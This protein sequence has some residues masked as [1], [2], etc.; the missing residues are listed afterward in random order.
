MLPRSSALSD[1]GRRGLEQEGHAAAQVLTPI[2]WGVAAAG[3]AQMWR[4]QYLAVLKK[5]EG[6]K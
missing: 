1:A 3:I 2:Q 6:L 5:P 4:D